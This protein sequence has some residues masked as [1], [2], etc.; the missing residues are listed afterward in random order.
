M[1]AAMIAVLVL[2]SGGEGQTANDYKITITGGTTVMLIL[3][4]YYNMVLQCS[5]HNSNPLW[6]N[7]RFF[8]TFAVVPPFS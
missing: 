3:L 7:F 4:D 8:Q 1:I 6:T 2:A 5:P